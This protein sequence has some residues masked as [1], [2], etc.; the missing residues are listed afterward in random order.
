[1]ES[2]KLKKEG[3]R[4]EDRVI[5]MACEQSCPTNA[6]TFGDLNDIKSAVSELEKDGRKFEM[7]EE[8]GVRPSVFYLTKVW[9]R[10]DENA[11]V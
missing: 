7:L 6:I 2:W 5:K 4:P 3:K 10:E 8:I 1:M 11:H 9:N